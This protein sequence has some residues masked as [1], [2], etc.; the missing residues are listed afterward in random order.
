MS[1]NPLTITHNGET[2]TVRQWSERLGIGYHTI[3]NRR[4]RGLTGAELLA[5]PMSLREIAHRGGKAGHRIGT[6]HQF[7][8]SEA[9]TAGRKGGQVAQA[10]R[11]AAKT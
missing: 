1:R 2:L 6:A 8:H 11:R 5:P 7:T 3:L 4:H 9:V 10:R